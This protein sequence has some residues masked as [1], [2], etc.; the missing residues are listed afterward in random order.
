MKM[1]DTSKARV[2]WIHI[3]R[4]LA[5]LAG[6]YLAR[7]FIRNG[8]A[9][10]DPEGFWAAPFERWGYPVWFRLLVGVIETAGGVLILIPWTATYAGVAVAAVMAGAFYTRFGS[11]FP[12]DLMWI[13]L[14]AI[15]LLWI[16]FEWRSFR[17]P[18]FDKRAIDPKDDS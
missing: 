14:Y 13:A 9:K 8:W 16:A 3:R 5:L 18:R 12:E 11:G 10:F 7:I 1:N 6:L 15:A 4:V 2:W 17:W